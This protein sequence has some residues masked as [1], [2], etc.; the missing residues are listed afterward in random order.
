MRPQVASAKVTMQEDGGPDPLHLSSS[1]WAR[2]AVLLLAQHIPR[3]PANSQDFHAEFA[4]CLLTD[5]AA[6]GFVFPR[7]P[8]LVLLLLIL[9]SLTVLLLD[10]PGH[11]LVPLGPLHPPAT[12][13]GA[14]F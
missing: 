11:T 9:A 12:P 13:Q 10:L 6:P 5:P 3:T 7:V 1:S 4:L 2:T 8:P 14:A